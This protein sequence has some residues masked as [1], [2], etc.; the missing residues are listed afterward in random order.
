MTN[1][2]HIEKLY[3]VRLEDSNLEDHLNEIISTINQIIDHLNH[4]PT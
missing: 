4:E 3:L 1:P 2:N